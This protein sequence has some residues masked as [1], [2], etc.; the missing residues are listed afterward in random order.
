[1]WVLTIWKKVFNTKQTAITWGSTTL[2]TVSQLAMLRWLCFLIVWTLKALRVLQVLEQRGHWWQNPLMW[3]STCSFTVYLMFDCLH[4]T[5]IC[6]CQNH[7]YGHHDNTFSSSSKESLG[8]IFIRPLLYT[9]LILGTH[10]YC[11]LLPGHCYVFHHQHHHCHLS[12]LL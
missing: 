5:F 8:F 9:V 11:K 1:M 6:C 3:V 12:L 7:H 10:P 2:V 4:D